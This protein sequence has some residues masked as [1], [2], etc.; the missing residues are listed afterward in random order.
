MLPGSA[1]ALEILARRG[2]VGY[3]NRLD[4]VV[5]WSPG[6]EPKVWVRIALRGV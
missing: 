2:T 6:L 4:S 3:C 1:A 5:P